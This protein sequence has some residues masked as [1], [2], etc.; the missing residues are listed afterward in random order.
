[1]PDQYEVEITRDLRR[2]LRAIYNFISKDSPQNASKMIVELLDA[3][4]GLEFLPHRFA[5]PRSR[6]SRG[7][8]IRAMPVW[9]Y[10][11]RYRI[12]EKQKRILVMHVW[13]GSRRKP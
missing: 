11:V 6:Y 3:I 9:P 5:V 1:M 10:V 8:N 7:R 4:E 13:H 12:V 2:E